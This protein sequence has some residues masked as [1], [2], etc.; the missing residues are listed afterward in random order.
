MAV[1][2]SSHLVQDLHISLE[3]LGYVIVRHYN[4][5]HRVKPKGLRHDL[6]FP[7]NSLPLAEISHN[8]YW[9]GRN[10]PTY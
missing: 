5:R 3:S 6:R 8:G 9:N 1:S 7:Q 2:T 4:S 10:P